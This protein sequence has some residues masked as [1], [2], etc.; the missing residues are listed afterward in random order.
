MTR[1]KVIERVAK[2]LF[3]EEKS[4]LQKELHCKKNVAIEFKN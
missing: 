3:I 2:D 4:C 1:K